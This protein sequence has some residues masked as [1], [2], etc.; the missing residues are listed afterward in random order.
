MGKKKFLVIV[1][2]LILISTVGITAW[3]STTFAEET[4]I[5]NW[6]RNTALWYGEGKINDGDFINALQWLMKEEILKI[7]PPDSGG[8][9]I[10]E[11][12]INFDKI[13]LEVTGIRELAGMSDVV[14]ILSISN[15]EFLAMPDVFSVIEQRENEW[16]TTDWE[17]ITPFMH[18]LIENNVSD[19]LREHANNYPSSIGVEFDMYPEIIL[20]NSFGV[21]IAQTGKTTDYLQGDE[22]WWMKAKADLLYISEIH[23][24]QSADVYSV[25]IGYRVSDD[26]GGF[27]GV[28]KAVTNVD[29][30]YKP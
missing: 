25:D 19:L 2:M 9:K 1:G 20:T 23:Y 6:I 10:V 4:L 22:I 24:D 16:T 3:S 27:L 30:F 28:I 11:K 17:D 21:N 5:P 15:N 29:Q 18:E 12:E 13:Y 14:Q 26:R 8:E 7:P